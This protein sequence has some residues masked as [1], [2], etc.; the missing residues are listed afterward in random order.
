MF[1]CAHVYHLFSWLLVE[2]IFQPSLESVLIGRLFTELLQ[3]S[4]VSSLSPFQPTTVFPTRTPPTQAGPPSGSF[5]WVPVRE[6]GLGQSPAAGLALSAPPCCPGL[7]GSE[8]QAELWSSRLV[9]SQ[10]GPSGDGPWA[11]AC[12]RFRQASP[13]RFAGN[14]VKARC[15]IYYFTTVSHPEQLS[16]LS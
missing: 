4:R 8:L 7:G 5:Y 9:W 2:P 10:P 6:A 14:W 15:V 12:A 11:V 16:Y 13:R 3:S 1:P